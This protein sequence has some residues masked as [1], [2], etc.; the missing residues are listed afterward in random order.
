MGKSTA[1]EVTN[2]MPSRFPAVL[3]TL[4]ALLLLASSAFAENV[5]IFLLKDGQYG[6]V[7]RSVPQ[8]A[9]PQKFA[10]EALAAGPTAEEYA[11][12]WR[13]Q[14]P[15]DAV[16]LSSGGRRWGFS[17]DFGGEG[18][19]R[20]MARADEELL[21]GQIT[22]TAEQFPGVFTLRLRKNGE[23]WRCLKRPIFSHIPIPVQELPWKPHSLGHLKQVHKDGSVSYTVLGALL[24]KR[25]AISPGHGWT[26]TGPDKWTLQREYWQGIVED[27]LNAEFMIYL[28]QYLEEAGARVIPV[29][30]LDK[31][32]GIGVS[33]HPKWQEA[34]KYY[35]ESQGAPDWIYQQSQNEEGADITCRGLYA[36]WRGADILVTL[37]NNG[38]RQSG[39]ETLYEMANGFQAES[40][41]L[42]DAVHNR[43]IATLR[44][45][46]VPDW[47]DRKVQ[48][49]TGNYGENNW[50]LQPSILIEVAFM[51][52]PEP[53]N[54]LLHDEKFK[55]AVARAMYE[56][57]CEY[58]DRDPTYKLAGPDAR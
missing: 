9:D 1:V 33:G 14:F 23:G 5:K 29:R 50:G 16:L 49:F 21:I 25:I 8:G 39:T 42:A 35:A 30:E 12:G 43:V 11:A 36:A 56:G 26:R 34:G 10:M 48:G 17:V 51:D 53:D 13:T 24:G 3:A 4:A 52:T 46:F 20:P 6:A 47:R 19:K 15:S 45:E 57:I 31:N 37:H 44:K 41:R 27:F 7:E 38:A 32:A 54:R 28:K 2:A 55:Q 58:F 18:L 22:R 40:K